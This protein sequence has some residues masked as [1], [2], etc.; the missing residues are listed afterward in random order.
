MIKSRQTDKGNEGKNLF[1]GPDTKKKIS[2][3]LT[4]NINEFKQKEQEKRE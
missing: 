4:N 2:F 1:Q 3:N